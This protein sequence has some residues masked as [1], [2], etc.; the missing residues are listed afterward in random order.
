LGNC[1]AVSSF[2]NQSFSNASF[3]PAV[4]VHHANPEIN[5][6]QTS[7]HAYIRTCIYTHAHTHSVVFRHL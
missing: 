2:R 5:T 3:I 6:K 7:I 1:V 4:P